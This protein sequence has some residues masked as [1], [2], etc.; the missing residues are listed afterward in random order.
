MLPKESEEEMLG[1][2]IVVVE[3]AGLFDCVLDDLLGSG[4]LGIDPDSPV[5]L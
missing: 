4:G 1:A 5:E 3:A 2:D